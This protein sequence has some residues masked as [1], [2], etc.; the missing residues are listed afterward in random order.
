MRHFPDF[1]GLALSDTIPPFACLVMEIARKWTRDLT[2]RN[3]QH[4]LKNTSNNEAHDLPV[5]ISQIVVVIDISKSPMVPLEKRLIQELR[6]VTDDRFPGFFG[7]IY[8]M[9]FGWMYQG[10]WQMVKLLLSE[11]AKS[12]VNFPSAKEVIEYIPEENLLEELGG[13]DEYE[14]TLDCDTILREYGSGWKME[15]QLAPSH[16]DDLP[17]TRPG[18]SLSTSSFS[19]DDFYDAL[20]SPLKEQ[21]QKQ[22]SQSI[23]R[24]PPSGYSSVYGTPG[25]LT[26][27]GI[28]SPSK[29]PSSTNRSLFPAPQPSTNRYFHLTGIHIPSFLATI[30]GSG[31]TFT[32]SSSSSSEKLNGIDSDGVCGVDLSYRLTNLALERQQDEDL[33]NVEALVVVEKQQQMGG[34]QQQRREPHFPH[35]LPA[36]DP[37]STYA[38]AP[39]KLQIRRSEQLLIR[40]TRRLFR[41]SFA[42]NGTL[43]WVLLYIFLRGP[44]ENSMKRLLAKMITDPRTMTYTTVGLTASLAGVLGA[45]LS[46]SL[47]Q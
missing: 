36:D 21:Q 12:K 34:L 20:E 10:L 47:G 8:V 33:D 38:G 1:G 37:H 29:Q 45:S 25:T 26:P 43:Y 13:K 30:F 14:W 3:E 27:I 39:L 9:N 35:L 31:P 40:T 16:A 17:V 18:R 22:R 2:R 42:Y 11:R 19:S 15:T 7:S 32:A 41:L 4:R 5:L 46:S 24:M 44:A 28:R 6:N 23:W